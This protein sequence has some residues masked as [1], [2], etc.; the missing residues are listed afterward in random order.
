MYQ[1]KKQND[2]NTQHKEKHRH[3]TIFTFLSF[4]LFNF[5]SIHCFFYTNNFVFFLFHS[6]LLQILQTLVCLCWSDYC[7]TCQNSWAELKFSLLPFGAHIQAT[8]PLFRC[9]FPMRTYFIFYITY[10]VFTWVYYFDYSSS[11]ERTPSV[12]LLNQQ[13]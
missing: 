3:F 10:L 6:D 12:Y 2:T 8:V 5:W 9:V 11:T 4:C 7:L 13:G 1:F